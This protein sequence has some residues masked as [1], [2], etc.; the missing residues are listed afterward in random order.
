MSSSFHSK[1]SDATYLQDLPVEQFS[2]QLTGG[3]LERKERHRETA[4]FLVIFAD[5]F[6]S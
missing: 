6:F 2:G 5:F 3:E 1:E 4:K